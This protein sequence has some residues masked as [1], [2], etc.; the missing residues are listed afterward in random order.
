MSIRIRPSSFAAAL[1]ALACSSATRAEPVAPA[2]RAEIDALLG[3][4]QS[5]GCQFNRNGSWY[6][7][8]EARSHLLRKLAYL[9]GKNLVRNSE[10]FI[11]QAASKSSSSGKP[12]LVRCAQ[13]A[14]VE[15]GPWLSNELKSIRSAAARPAAAPASR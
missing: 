10:Q 14:A 13:V 8:A 1:L 3:R 12:Y 6:D 9:E 15:S 7:A 2:V 4:L 5:S 11:E